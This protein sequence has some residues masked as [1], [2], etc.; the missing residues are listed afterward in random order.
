[1]AF[2]ILW[3]IYFE[4]RQLFNFD[5]ISPVCDLLRKLNFDGIQQQTGRMQICAMENRPISIE[6]MKI[7]KFIKI[8]LFTRPQFKL[9]LKIV[10]AEKGFW[11]FE[12][13]EIESTPKK[14][15][16]MTK[17]STGKKGKG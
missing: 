7:G 13:N 2:V 9:I 8:N 5:L 12:A 16:K 11:P 6:L 10:A 17:S 15:K 14:K 1:M 3:A 4:I